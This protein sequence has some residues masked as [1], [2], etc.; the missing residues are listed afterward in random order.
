MIVGD[1]IPLGIYEEAGSLAEDASVIR[2]VATAIKQR[3]DTAGQAA[4]QVGLAR[5][6]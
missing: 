3:T 6:R 2:I 1:H 4:A 5:K